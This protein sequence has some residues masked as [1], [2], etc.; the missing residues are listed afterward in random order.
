MNLCTNASYAM[1]NSNGVLEISLKSITVGVRIDNT[2]LNLKHGD[3]IELKVSDSGAGIPRE[4]I[5]SIFEPY[6]TT[7]A[8]GEGTGMGLA[9]VHGI[10]ESYNGKI[11]VDSILGKGTTFT[12][13]LPVVRQRK[14]LDR[15]ET[16]KLPSGWESILF[17]DDEASI[18]KMGS[19]SLESLGY[20]VT[21]RTSSVD[22]LELFRS[23]PNA[24]DLV[25]TD[26]TM[27]NMTGDVLASELMSI[28]PDIPVILCTGYSKKITEGMASQIGI[29]AFAYKPI[30]KADLAKI[31]R[32][33]LDV[34]VE[35]RNKS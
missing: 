2:K 10:V 12:I 26:M 23:K 30:V 33:V 24:F 11:T 9:M 5:N 35:F 29:K 16:E 21:V 6:F 31:V 4:I 15:F 8:P 3:Y 13:Y 19:R 27:P 1:E 28:R 18:A 7:K 14:S 25:M 20:S 17:V 22:A 34:S 32:K